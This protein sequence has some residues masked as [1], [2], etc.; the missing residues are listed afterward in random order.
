MVIFELEDA[1]GVID[2]CT[3]CMKLFE[4][5]LDTLFPNLSNEINWYKTVSGSLLITFVHRWLQG[6]ESLEIHPRDDENN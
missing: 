4:T 5:F 6:V 1:W 2:T 3:T